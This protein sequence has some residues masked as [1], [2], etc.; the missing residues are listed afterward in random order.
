M[1]RVIR[2]TMPLLLAAAL[3]SCGLFDYSGIVSHRYALV[4]GVSRYTMEELPGA[5]PNLRYPDK[6]AS[7]LAATLQADGYVVSSRWVDAN[8]NVYKDGMPQG[9]IG[10]PETND[11]ITNVGAPGLGEPEAPSKVN[12]LADIQGLSGT[13]GPNDVLVIYFSG[14]GTQDTS[15]PPREYFN[16][17]E[18]VMR[19]IPTGTYGDF[20]LFSVRDDELR[21]AFDSIGTPRKVLVL[22]TC[23]SGGFIGNTLE[24]D[25]TQDPY[26]GAWPLVTPMTWIQAISNYA[27]MQASPTGI[28]PYGAQVLSAAGRNERSYENATLGHGVMTCFLLE[29]L[30]GSRADLNRD[31]HVTVLEAFAYAKAGVDSNWNSNSGVIASSQTFEPHVSGGP[32]DFVLF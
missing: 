8:G 27:A 14:H 1:G 17:Y 21:A 22:D 29:G 25:T 10:S 18:S 7:E 2:R 23:N 31:G 3:A 16:P 4:Y 24:V 26:T 32:V 20:P 13:V 19:Y 11:G 28:S 15:S 6:D 5:D 9:P 12:I 30:Q